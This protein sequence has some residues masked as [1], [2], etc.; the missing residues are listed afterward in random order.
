M[1]NDEQQLSMDL[2]VEQTEWGKWVDPE[3]RRV[4]AQ[5]FMDYA[6]I[7]EI[8]SEP[9]PEDSAEV[10]RLDPIVSALFPDLATAMAPE[11]SDLSDAFICFMGQCFIELAG[12]EWIEYEWPGEECTFYPHVNPALRFDTEDE[13]ETTAWYLMK[14]MIEHRDGMFSDLAETIREYAGYHAEKRDGEA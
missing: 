6:G 10:K 12:A 8:P 13:D 3:R 11:N 1:G 5:K 7:R 2:G 4:Q 9:W 14:S